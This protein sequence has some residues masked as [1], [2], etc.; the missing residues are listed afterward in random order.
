MDQEDPEDNL[1][2]LKMFLEFVDLN[3]KSAKPVMY[4]R[5]VVFLTSI[6]GRKYEL[7]QGK[8]EQGLTSKTIQDALK[9]DKVYVQINSPQEFSA[10]LR[11]LICLTD[12]LFGQDCTARALILPVEV[13]PI[14]ETVKDT[15][16]FIQMEEASTFTVRGK[17]L[18]LSKGDVLKVPA[19][20]TYQVSNASDASNGLLLSIQIGDSNVYSWSH[21]FETAM[22]KTVKQLKDE[23]IIDPL[24]PAFLFSDVSADS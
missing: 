2:A 22:T 16:L 1:V 13:T 5:D 12:E 10:S 7:N 6:N 24:P 8:G 18:T 20:A 9:I 3:A 15:H 14:T 4:E 11:K 19:G 23:T 17:T 21:V